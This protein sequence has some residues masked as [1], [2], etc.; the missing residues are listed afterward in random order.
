[1]CKNCSKDFEK[2]GKKLDI[3]WKDTAG[4]PLQLLRADP[5]KDGTKCNE[6]QAINIIN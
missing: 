1:L 4:H 5:N 3:A 6:C 2:Y